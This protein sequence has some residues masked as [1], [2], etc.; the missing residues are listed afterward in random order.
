MVKAA[1][2]RALSL[3]AVALM[4]AVTGAVLIAIGDAPAPES[5]PAILASTLIHYL[6]YF[7]L[8]QAYRVGDLSQVYPISRGLAPALVAFGT[9]ALI[10]ETLS[11]LGWVGLA[12]VSGG[13]G[14]LALQRGAVHADP[15][16]VAFATL[17]G[18][19][20]GAYSVADGIGVRLSG[21]P[22]GYMGWLF[23]L[24]APV[25][26]FVLG[27]RRMRRVALDRR[28]LWI[29]LVGGLF[30]VAAY[31]VVL[32]AK[33]I[34]PIAAVSAV[35]ESSV[36]IAALIGIVFFGERPWRG[37]LVCAGIVAAGVVTLAMG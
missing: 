34:A 27:Q 10:G 22:L 8:F 31:G 26:L 33:T 21:S 7:L 25:A 17:V 24:E 1:G 13:I 15:R 29:G 20:I 11:P 36:I 6:Y 18:L 12:A 37:R 16:A 5:W 4:H 32:Y 23:L 14:L 35:R 28:T 3:A 2:D 30:S 19:T 9:F